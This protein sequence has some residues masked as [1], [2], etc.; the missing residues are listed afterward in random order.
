MSTT[1]SKSTI[2]VLSTHYVL[3]IP[4]SVHHVFAAFSITGDLW[5]NRCLQ[6]TTRHL[7]SI[8]VYI[9]QFSVA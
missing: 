8:Q 2:S 4:L 9:K 7:P 1:P 5:L 6:A 3:H